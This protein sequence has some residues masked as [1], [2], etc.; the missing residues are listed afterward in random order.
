MKIEILFS[1]VNK[2]LVVGKEEKYVIAKTMESDKSGRQ[3]SHLFSRK[4]G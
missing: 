2:F 1:F 3:V 4:K